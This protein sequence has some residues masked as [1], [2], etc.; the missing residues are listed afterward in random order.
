M[1]EF[2]FIIIIGTIIEFN[3]GLIFICT[4]FKDLRLTYSQYLLKF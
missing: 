2:V 4:Y 3:I 1:K